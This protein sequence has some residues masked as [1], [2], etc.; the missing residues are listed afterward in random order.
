MSIVKVELPDVTLHCLTYGASNGPLA[1]CLH[2]FPDTP[3]SFRYLGP[4]LAA[5]GYRVVTP[6]MRGYA[7]SSL[8]RSANYQ[9]PALANDANRLHERLGG[10]E[11]AVLIGHDWGAAAAYPAIAVEP[12]RWRRAVAMAVPPLAI[13]GR[14]FMD[15]D[16]LQASWYMFFFQN[17][18]ADYVF[19]LDDLDFAQRLW[20]LWSPGIDAT[21]DLRHL[22]QSLGDAEHRAA[23]L[24]YYR[25]MFAPEMIDPTLAPL[26]AAMNEV[27]TVP[28]L[29]LHGEND[30][31]IFLDS[32]GDPLEHLAAQSRFEVIANAGH[33]MHVEQP[34]AVHRVIDEFLTSQ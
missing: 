13:M 14:A 15:F 26:H 17:P 11:R 23:A 12:Q 9:L 4:H 5:R 7:P 2:G 21:E 32:L 3:H 10:D 28:V 29:Y 27:S 34:E 8:S 30:R 33:F 25:A 16:Q 20:A 1:L 19:A 18:L 6:F 22:R 24:G 31:C